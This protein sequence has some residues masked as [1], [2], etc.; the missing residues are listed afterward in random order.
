MGRNVRAAAV[1]AVQQFIASVAIYYDFCSE[2][3]PVC[4][5]KAQ[6]Q[7]GLGGPPY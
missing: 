1:A 7:G 5:V 3:S 4:K 6:I 2:K